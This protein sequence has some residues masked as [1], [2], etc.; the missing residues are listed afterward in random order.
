[1]QVGALNTLNKCLSQ[2]LEKKEKW[3]P[4][5]VEAEWQEHCV[6]SV[7]IFPTRAVVSAETRS[8]ALCRGDLITS[9]SSAVKKKRKK[10][11]RKRRPFS[12]SFCLWTMCPSRQKSF[13]YGLTEV[14]RSCQVSATQARGRTIR[15]KLT[16][17]I[18]LYQ[19]HTSALIDSGD[20]LFLRPSD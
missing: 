16:I 10:K 11:S 14:F 2:N 17:A 5:D 1:M 13:L 4:R 7:C 6:S 12:P 19:D 18:L 3:I 9:A 20:K 8:V 15:A